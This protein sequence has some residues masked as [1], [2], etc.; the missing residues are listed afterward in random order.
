[1]AVLELDLS[2]FGG[3]KKI[4]WRSLRITCPGS[5]EYEKQFYTIWNG[6]ERNVF[7]Q[8]SRLPLNVC[9]FCF[10]NSRLRYFSGVTGP[11]LLCGLGFLQTLFLHKNLSIAL[12]GYIH[13]IATAVR[14]SSQKL[15]ISVLLNFPMTPKCQENKSSSFFVCFFASKPV[16]A[17]YLIFS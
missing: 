14:V 5:K 12:A 13:H 8:H 4:N 1:M 9:S 16:L 17:V 6:L 7:I 3:Q 2:R 15:I 11:Y 10:P